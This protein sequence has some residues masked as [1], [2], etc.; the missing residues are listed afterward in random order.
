MKWKKPYFSFDFLFC[1]LVLHKFKNAA[2]SDHRKIQTVSFEEN[3][4]E[5]FSLFRPIS[6]LMKNTISKFYAWKRC[7]Q[8]YYNLMSSI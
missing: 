6:I 2:E 7:I 5:L 1:K 3:Q 8:H 4:S